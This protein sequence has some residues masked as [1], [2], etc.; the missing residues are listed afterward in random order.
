MKVK[1]LGKIGMA[2]TRTVGKTKLWTKI[3]KPEILVG[4]G[5]VAG[6]AAIVTAAIQGT[7]CNDILKELDENLENVEKAKEYAE[8]D[9]TEYTEEEQKRDRTVYKL[10][11]MGKVVKKMAVPAALGTAMVVCT[12]AGFAEQKRRYTRMAGAFVSI[13]GTFA[14]YRGRCRGK[15]GEAADKYCLTGL[16][17]KEIEV[18]KYDEN[19]KAVVEK[20]KVNDGE[21][22]EDVRQNLFA[23]E[24]SPKTSTLAT[25]DVTTNIQLLQQ[26]ENSAHIH[27]VEYWSTN[28][29]WIK[30]KAQLDRKIYPPT[31]YGEMFGATCHNNK[32]G[33]PIR[34]IHLDAH[35]IPGRQD[36]AILVIVEGML[37]MI[38]PKKDI[39]KALGEAPYNS[40]VPDSWV[41][42]EEMFNYRLWQHKMKSEK[43]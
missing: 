26:V 34:K 2:I 36:G 4:V 14:A 10:Q 21:L 23:F 22:A 13:C 37:P 7:K 29:N 6:A 38:D 28:Y 5:L 16:E 25:Y 33:M 15:F 1:A 32:D 8:M 39:T 31:E 27:M 9:D 20:R 24:F 17:E 41:G 35:A 19:G 42:S 11:A 43:E 40:P 18:T 12:M 30:N 3:H